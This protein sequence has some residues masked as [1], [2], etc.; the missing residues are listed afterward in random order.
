[1][2][3]FYLKPKGFVLERCKQ[4]YSQLFLHMPS[5]S[6]IST[7]TNG[8]TLKLGLGIGTDKRK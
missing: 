7:I 2:I 5:L 1:M 6:K 8:M 3:F 4:Y